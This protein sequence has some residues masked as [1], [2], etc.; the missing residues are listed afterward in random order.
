MRRPGGRSDGHVVV[1]DLQPLRDWLAKHPDP[2]ETVATVGGGEMSVVDGVRHMILP[3]PR[4]TQAVLDFWN[5]LR[6]AGWDYPDTLDY[7][8]V[9]ERWRQEHEVAQIRADHLAGMDRHTL[10]NL[11]RWYDRSERFSTGTWA[12]GWQAG[13][14]HAAARALIA[15]G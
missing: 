14:F 1:A 5:A 8:G 10:F 11:L 13:I 6:A 4:Y 12:G 2:R 7:A 3:Y 15:L 9:V